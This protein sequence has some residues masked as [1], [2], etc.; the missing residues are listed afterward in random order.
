MTMMPDCVF[1]R[2]G[3]VTLDKFDDANASP[4]AAKIVAQKQIVLDLGQT[5]EAAKKASVTAEEEKV[6][7]GEI[8]KLKEAV[9]KGKLILFVPT[10]H[11]LISY[12]VYD[13]T[14]AAETE[15]NSAD[16]LL[17]QLW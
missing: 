6:T 3:E 7:G 8:E 14:C 10:F 12:L 11:R 13:S 16:D 2:I 4:L 9:I 1:D 15:K 17:K 5:L